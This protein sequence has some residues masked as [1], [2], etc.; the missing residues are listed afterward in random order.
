MYSDADIKMI[1]IGSLT[2]D[3]EETLNSVIYRGLGRGVDPSQP[4]KPEG[5]P[6]S[7]VPI[8]EEEPDNVSMKAQS[9]V[10]SE[11]T[12]TS[13]PN[14]EVV[15]GSATK[16]KKIETILRKEPV[17][18]IKKLALDE[19]GA[20]IM[21]DELKNMI[22]GMSGYDSDETIIYN[23]GGLVSRDTP[24]VSQCRDQIMHA[25]TCKGNKKS[26]KSRFHI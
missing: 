4:K 2:F 3:E 18:K 19:N 6:F 8:K 15:K 12:A 24:K 13:Q 16:E 10:E 25:T 23:L 26:A 5:V 1:E 11:T 14:K 17:V 22:K 7:Q 21:T 9:L 20:I